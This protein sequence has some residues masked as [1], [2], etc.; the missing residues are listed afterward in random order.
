MN[1][2]I[3]MKGLEGKGIRI[4]SQ[5]ASLC[6]LKFSF[7]HFSRFM[8]SFQEAIAANLMLNG[9][10]VAS[11]TGDK[12]CNQKSNYQENRLQAHDELTSKA[13][14]SCTKHICRCINTYSFMYGHSLSSYRLCIGIFIQENKDSV[15]N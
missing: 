12:I 13:N 1:D 3:T 15:N 4:T 14:Q 11:N 5:K 2:T 8:C 6:V 7:N 10:G 9:N